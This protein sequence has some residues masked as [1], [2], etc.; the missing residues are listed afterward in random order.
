MYF[1]NC[2]ALYAVGVALVVTLPICTKHFDQLS[3]N[4]ISQI[5]WVWAG[6]PSGQRPWGIVQCKRHNPSSVQVPAA[7]RSFSNA[8]FQR[9]T[10]A[11]RRPKCSAH[12]PSS[13]W[14][15]SALS[16]RWLGL[17]RRRMGHPWPGLQKRVE[18][19]P[20]T[21]SFSSTSAS[22]RHLSKVVQGCDNPRLTL[23]PTAG[24]QPPVSKRR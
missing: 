10:N 4:G 23:S 8:G 18:T 16:A 6:P 7:Q 15:Q 3:A 14:R 24:T 22:Q 9:Q 5:L 12:S 21:A 1:W 19:A 13:A 17:G 20:I 11:V 2:T